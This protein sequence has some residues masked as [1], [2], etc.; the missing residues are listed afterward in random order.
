MTDFIKWDLSGIEGKN[1]ADW[2]AFFFLILIHSA[3]AWGL[4]CLTGRFG[5]INM[6]SL[7][8]EDSE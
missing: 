6:L 7:I 8:Q 2:G 5:V 3:Q 4:W 1:Q